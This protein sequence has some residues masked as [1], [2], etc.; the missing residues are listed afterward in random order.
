MPIRNIMQEQHYRIDFPLSD[1][2][3]EKRHLE[4]LEKID[5]IQD[6]LKKD[7]KIHGHRGLKN[8]TCY[9]PYTNAAECLFTVTG[10]Q[11]WLPEVIQ[12]IKR[13]PVLSKKDS[14]YSKIFVQEIFVPSFKPTKQ[15]LKAEKDWINAMQAI[16]FGDGVGVLT[17][18]A[19][20][21]RRE[22]ETKRIKEL[23]QTHIDT[24]NGETGHT[25]IAKED[26]IR[27]ELKK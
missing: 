21:K 23:L 2:P 5:A 27:K 15:K 24:G 20:T 9:A 26:K 4:M 6:Y 8:L 18:E 11:E 12:Q 17:E 13:D 19:E 3:I 10:E 1:K 7:L 14:A 16:K 25:I 22:E